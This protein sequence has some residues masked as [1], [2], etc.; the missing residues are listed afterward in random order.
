MI[1]ANCDHLKLIQVGISMTNSKGESPEGQPLAWQFN[2]YF[3]EQN[4]Q[5][6]DESM[7]L[8]RTSGFNFEKHKT[9]GIP[10]NLLAEYLITSGLCMN[11]NNHWITF[12]GGVDFGYLLRQLMGQ[13]LP[14]NQNEFSEALRVFFGSTYDC[15]ELKREIDFL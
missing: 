8:L 2:L 4:E 11:R 14:T 9:D 13:N 10:H 6:I 3:D 15:K 1:R 5:S 7:A 12:H